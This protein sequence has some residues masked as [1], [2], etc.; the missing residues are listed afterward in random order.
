[1][2]FNARLLTE[3]DY[4]K[5]LSFWKDNRFPAPPKDALPE[6]G[7]GGIMIQKDGIDICAGFIY[8]TNSKIVWLEYVIADFNYREKDRKE[9]IQTLI[10]ELCGIAQRKGFKYVFTSLKNENLIK[11]FEEVGFSKGY[12]NTT[13]MVLKL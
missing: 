10:S 4:D 7:T 6:N 12:N 3:S 9:A 11:R 2:I 5:L 8:F 13:E 1:M